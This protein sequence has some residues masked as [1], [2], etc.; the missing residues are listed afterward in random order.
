LKEIWEVLQQKYK[1]AD[2]IKKIRLQS[3]RGE[4]E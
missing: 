1:G 3:L 4:F 2:K